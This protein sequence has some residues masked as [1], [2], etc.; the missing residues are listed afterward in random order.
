VVGLVCWGACAAGSDS[1][2]ST[3]ANSPANAGSASVA[4]GLATAGS[5]SA[6]AGSSAGGALGAAG[7][8]TSGSV[9]S[10][11]AATVNGGA[12]G[13][14]GTS[15]AAGSQSVAGTAGAG[16]ALASPPGFFTGGYLSRAPWMG[17]VFTIVDALGSTVSPVCNEAGCTPT[18]GAQA[19]ASGTVAKNAASATFAGLAFHAN[20]PMGGPRGT[21]T[22]TGAGI[23]VS[24]ANPPTLARLQLQEQAASD[25]T[26]Y[27]AP[28][29][30]G[31]TGLIP[32]ESFKTFCWGDAA[33]PSKAFSVGTKVHE[34]TVMVP[35]NSAADVP[36]NF[37]LVDIQPR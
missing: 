24:V 17:Y 36:Y 26:R 7:A 20:D 29:P 16:G 8:G 23:Y 12:A 18:W 33:H 21:W 22:S 11:G 5:G 37:C 13:S 32:F 19:C 27:C 25:N 9:G 34:V 10:S 6:Q 15:G 35:G 30:A 14:G 31:G 3:G 1:E 28:L 2:P 4:G